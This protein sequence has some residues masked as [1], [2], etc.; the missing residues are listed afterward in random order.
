MD[1]STARIFS[2]GSASRAAT[3]LPNEPSLLRFAAAVLMEIDEDWQT[4][5]VYLSLETM[6][7]RN[8]LIRS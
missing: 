4:G 2:C 3:L 8:R 6:N 1:E 7:P 5:K